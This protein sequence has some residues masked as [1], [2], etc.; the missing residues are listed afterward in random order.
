[1]NRLLL[2]EWTKLRTVPRWMLTLGAAAVL[3]VL[4]AV[5]NT[6]G[7]SVSGDGGGGGGDAP[8][9]VR[10]D[11]QDG[12]TFRYQDLRGDGSMVA[13]VARQADS[14]QWAKAGLLLRASG[15]RGGPYAALMVT[16]DHG[17]HL[18]SGFGDTDVAGS[19]AG[20]PRWL[21]LDRSG[22]S[23]TGYESADGTD[24]RRVGSVELD[25]LT[26]G[27]R[28][29]VFVASPDEVSV[30]RMYGGESVT[31]HSTN[32]SATFTGVRADPPA[33]WHDDIR[34]P[35]RPEASVTGAA[36]SVTLVGGGDIGPDGFVEDRAQLLLNGVLLGL[37]AV[38]ALGVLFVTA[39]YRRGTILTTFAASPR[40]GRVL[41]AK[42]LVL[43]A[44]TFAA[45]LVAAF[46]SFLVGS[47]IAAG[48]GFAMPSLTEPGVL[49][50]VVGTAALLAVVAVL[51]LGV[52]MIV[53]RSTPAISVVLL[54]LIVPDIVATGLPLGVAAWV[55][56]LTPAAGFAIQDTVHRYDTAIAPWAG[57][58]V[59][60]A[61]A[62]VALAIAAWRLDRRDA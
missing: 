35:M 61:Y 15:Q 52:A 10:R 51:A 58:G 34:G 32:G 41:A 59:L 13:K 60:C 40:R 56:R 21:R 23:V 57:F 47:A 43:G 26:G 44:A 12:G 17:V 25:E 38:V 54:L 11:V 29:G 62:A 24:W 45:G 8:P 30:K 46:T 39:E 2:A 33:Q 20:A 48:K 7:I 28:L 42:A 9:N 31:G 37:V 49:R 6:A 14:H 4:V 1:V 19:S 22:T 3:T 36:D 18:Q 50:A 27:A 5:L 16:P 55:Q 53:R